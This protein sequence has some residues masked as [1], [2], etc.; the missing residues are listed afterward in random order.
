[1]MPKVKFDILGI[2]P[3]N[4]YGKNGSTKHSDMVGLYLKPT[5]QWA[6]ANG[7]AWGVAETGLSD[8]ASTSNPQWVRQTFASVEEYDGIAMSYFNTDLNAYLHWEL[9]TATKIADFT[10]AIKDTPALR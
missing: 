6:K 5:A 10:A 8:E 1:M 2:D 9:N 4:D 3:Y 7:V